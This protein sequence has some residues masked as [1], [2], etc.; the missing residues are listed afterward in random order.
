VLIV[1]AFILLCL[2]NL[3]LGP[4]ALLPLPSNLPLAASCFLGRVDPQQACCVATVEGEL[5]LDSLVV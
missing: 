2:S 1:I 3:H 4:L 5:I